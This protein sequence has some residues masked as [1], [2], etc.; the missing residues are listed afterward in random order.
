MFRQPFILLLLLSVF[1]LAFFIAP[2]IAQAVGPINYLPF[3]GTVVLLCRYHVNCG[4][5]QNFNGK[6]TDWTM[7]KGQVT[8]AAGRGT[9]EQSGS[10]GSYGYSVTLSHANNYWSRYAHLWYHFP[11]VDDVLAPGMPIGYT[12]NTGCDTPLPA[13]AFHL[14]WQVYQQTTYP[15]GLDSGVDPAPI[16]M[17]APIPSIPAGKFNITSQTLGFTNNTNYDSNVYGCDEV[18]GCFVFEGSDHD[19]C[20]WIEGDDQAWS[21]LDIAEGYFWNGANDGNRTYQVHCPTVSG[22]TSTVRG[23]WVPS[24]PNNQRIPNG[25]YRIYAFLPDHPSTLHYP[26]S[27]VYTAY[28]DGIAQVS[29]TANQENAHGDLFY[30][31]TI[32]MNSNN[33]YTHVMVD[34]RNGGSGVRVAYDAVFWAKE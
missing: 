22:S 26:G 18:Y 16:P 9:T 7:A 13:C 17:P 15:T 31:G 21:N 33:T 1:V 19:E 27:V 8:Y 24:L 28:V 20:T 34:N 5:A 4:T 30:I 32:T 29:R 6:G 10:A 11:M 14:H 2:K 12:S 3:K 25:T 23:F